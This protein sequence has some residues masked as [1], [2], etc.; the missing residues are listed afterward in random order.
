MS[1][2]KLSGFQ[3]RKR[4]VEYEK[5]DTKSRKLMAGFL[6]TNQSIAY[7]EVDSDA[8]ARD[9]C[10]N[11]YQN[12]PNISGVQNAQ[13]NKNNEDQDDDANQSNISEEINT[14]ETKNVKENNDEDQFEKSS[15][16]DELEQSDLSKVILDIFKYHDIAYLEFDETSHLPKISQ[17]L[18][19]EMIIR[20]SEYFQNKSGPFVPSGGRSMTVSWFKR[21]LA[22]QKGNEVNRSW[23]L[24]SPSKKA[25]YC[26]SC[27]LFPSSK[28]NTRSSFELATGFSNWKKPEKLSAHENSPSH[29]KSFTSWKETERRL[30]KGKILDAELEAQIASEK[31]RWRDVLDRLLACIKYFATQNLPLRGHSESL[32]HD[33]GKNLGNF[34]SLLKLIARYDPLLKNHLNYAIENPHSTSYLSPQIQNEFIHLLSS[35]VRNKLVNDIKKNKYY[36]ILLD[37]TPDLAHREQLSE[38]IRYVDIDFVNKTVVIKESFL[39]F[40][41]L[42]AKNAASIEKVIVEKLNSDNISL[43][44]CRSQCYDNAAVMAGYISGVQQRICE[45]NHR[46]LFVNCDNHSLNLVG[47]HSAKQDPLVVTFFGKLENIYLFFS[48]STLRWE[49]LKKAVKKTVKRESETR[50]SARYE[51]VNA[52]F[53]GLD[54]LVNLLEKMSGDSNNT[55]ETRSE[56]ECLLENILNFNFLVLLHFWNNILRR[57][58]R[59]QKRLQDHTMNFWDAACDLKSLK[60]DINNLRDE[61]CQDAV[62]YGKMKCESWDIDIERRIRRRRKMPGEVT[63]DVGL[64]ASEE[65]M[66]VMK[67]VL[68]RLQQE[69]IT[70]FTRLE[71]LNSKFGFL[72]NVTELLHEKDTDNLRQHC[73]NFGEFYNIDV[74][75]NELYSE[76][77]DAKMLL[78]TR[79]DTLPDTP[80]KLLSFIISYGD[81]V[82]PNLCV[83]LQILLTI[84]VSIASCERSFSKL[85]L[86]LSYLRTSMGQNRLSDLALLSIEKETLDLVDFNEVID[87]FA[88]TKARKIN[89]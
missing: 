48:R 68:D 77:C 69:I 54:A 86:I 73:S 42:H 14:D 67:S 29:R 50:W 3:R 81:D 89:I 32:S 31:Q 57:F 52:L 59:V 4:K 21:R 74:D 6:K 82:F 80:M 47:V 60:I 1:G 26:F 87:K 10:I 18:R 79:G 76:I 37:S 8:E 23:L 71:D 17:Q 5:E 43:D 65:I 24:Y 61:F 55:N 12:E 75:G 64:S 46:A 63:T 11:N 41:E 88:I 34:L 38:V 27:L 35:A 62:E 22:N 9:D 70:R 56:A 25:A 84:A 45:R 51:A 15:Y 78:H 40:I 83:A 36:G 19:T 13:L 28:P 53:D 44:N 7:K 58:D 16:S 39:G 30:I 49:E 20:G 2:K 66:R 33:D 85:K 72:L